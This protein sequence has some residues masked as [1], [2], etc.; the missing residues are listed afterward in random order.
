MTTS[1]ATR[2]VQWT[3]GN[4]GRR[5][6]LAICSNPELDLVGCYAWSRDKVGRDVGELSGLDEPVGAENLIRGSHAASFVLVDETT[7]SVRSSQLR[8]IRRRGRGSAPGPRERSC[9]VEGPVWSMGVV[10][11]DVLGEYE[12]ELTPN[13]DQHSV[14]TL[15]ADRADES[16]GEGVGP[17]GSDRRADDADPLRPEDL[18]KAGR[19][20]GV[21]G[22][23][24][25]TGSDEPSRRAPW[26]GCG[27]AG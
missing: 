12:L 21:L 15:A 4:V 6:V 17:R 8:R 24:R 5:S 11:I 10:M 9:L 1:R 26:R 27:P 3:T 14:E 7:E 22:P 13:E 23:A 20:L 2:V 18:V 19:E 25:G 16:L